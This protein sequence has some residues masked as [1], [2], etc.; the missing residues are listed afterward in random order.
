[1]S[2]IKINER[3][4]ILAQGS[5]KITLRDG[6]WINYQ[7]DGHELINR[8]S[9][10]L[11]C[12]DVNID[13]DWL[14]DSGAD[15]LRYEEKNDTLCAVY[16]L[17]ARSPEKTL[18]AWLRTA[19]EANGDNRF[20]YI[21]TSSYQIDGD[22]LLRALSIKRLRSGS[23]SGFTP[24][25]LK[26]FLFTFNGAALEEESD[27]E[28]D[29]P[30]AINLKDFIPPRMP[31][32]KAAGM[33]R[34][35]GSSYDCEPGIA[36]IANKAI[37]KTFYA[38][39]AA[40]DTSYTPHLVGNG[41]NITFA[42]SEKRFAEWIDGGE[43]V[44]SQCQ[45]SLI[46]GC[47]IDAL[48]CHRDYV[49]SIM[50]P[51]ESIPSWTHDAIIMEVDTEY[52][53]GFKGLESKLPELLQ[54]GINCLYLMPINEGSYA[55]RDHYNINPALGDK[56]S[57]VSLVSAAH[58]SGMHVLLDLLLVIMTPDALLVR[59]H[60]EYFMRD[61]MGRLQ[62]HQAWANV[63]T[64]YSNAGFRKYIIDFCI[65][66]V[67]EYGIDGFRVDSAVAKPPN[68]YPHTGKQPHD[69]VMAAFSLLNEVNGAIKNVNPEAI[70]LNEL[71]SMTYL[72]PCDLVHSFGTL[73]KVIMEE[74][75][76]AR[77]YQM[78]LADLYAFSPAPGRLVHYVRNHDTAWFYKFE[79][80][81]KQFFV[82]E[83]IHYM[84]FGI[85]LI[86]SGQ[87]RKPEWGAPPPEAMKL[88]GKLADIRKGYRIFTDG[89]CDMTAV[90]ADDPGLFCM[91]R[92]YENKKLIFIANSSGANVK[93]EISF[94]KSVDAA[95]LP[96]AIDLLSNNPN[97]AVLETIKPNL[98]TAALEPYQ[99]IAL[100]YE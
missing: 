5:I 67:S 96:N 74:G 56:S 49:A 34:Q 99:T 77:D 4:A 23:F 30:S 50:P 87:T 25:R 85:P 79:G 32:S 38:R 35:V 47:Q 15:F 14:F 46:R 29:L 93:P 63:S 51:R 55:V 57:L 83:T 20:E 68:W 26:G 53:G 86:F 1:M 73:Y 65:Y 37:N 42:F 58:L 52:M 3:E 92:T 91:Y 36:M 45:S 19:E 18:P 28:V 54:A 13:D 33:Y 43:A 76:S 24:V 39:L 90:T 81:T 17:M 10:P 44:S 98:I 27:C 94:D 66:C 69:N 97:P 41:D 12:V 59:E 89:T 6:L 95:G 84:I 2:G 80:Y 31:Y 72:N 40:F 21:V 7:H 75:Y 8:R 9:A 60:P 88:Y 16:G 71:G 22:M 78:H 11:P 82:Y 70:L 48:K 100:Y 64:D 62:P 61:T